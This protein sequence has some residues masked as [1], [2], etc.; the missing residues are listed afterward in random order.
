MIR[1][2]G[3][4]TYTGN[5]INITFSPEVTVTL[6]AKNEGDGSTGDDPDP[7]VKGTDYEIEISPKN[8]PASELLTDA[9]TYV[10]TITGAFGV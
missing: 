6:P 5:R 4:I 2:S 7:L 8:D 3:I 10:Y 1:R 9:D